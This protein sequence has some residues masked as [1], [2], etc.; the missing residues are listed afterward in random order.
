MEPTTTRDI[1][2]RTVL[3]TAA[4]GV[5]VLALAV[6]APAAVASGADLVLAESGP[7]QGTDPSVLSF[8]LTLTGLPELPASSPGEY[9]GI[10][11]GFCLPDGLTVE[12]V[13]STSN[14]WSFEPTA[15][16]YE[17]GETFVYNSSA[18]A[19]GASDTL[20]VQVRQSPEITGLHGSLGADATV[21]TT[22]Y[23]QDLQWEY[24]YGTPSGPALLNCAKATQPA[25][26]R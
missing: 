23:T 12:S 1:R 24:S 4:W 6:A 14:G 8:V 2:R 5:P 10:L 20:L 7:I 9:V 25:T 17:A 22:G 26:P 11:L 18:I 16:P 13:S 19:A 21:A 15:D 3:A